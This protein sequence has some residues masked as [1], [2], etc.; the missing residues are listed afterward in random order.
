MR[1]KHTRDDKKKLI[2]KK[3]GVSVQ[4]GLIWVRRSRS[5]LLECANES[6]CFLKAKCVTV[7]FSPFY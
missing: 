5:K 6:M 1:I 3:Q 2:L 4:I 7:S